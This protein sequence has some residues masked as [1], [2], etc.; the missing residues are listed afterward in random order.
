MKL[1][2]EVLVAVVAFLS[3]ITSILKARQAKGSAEDAKVSE[4]T[5][6]RFHR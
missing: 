2:V 6:R 3:A 4:A 5:V 1:I